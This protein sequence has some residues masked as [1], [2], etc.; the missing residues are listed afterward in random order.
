M[1]TANFNVDNPLSPKLWKNVY[2]IIVTDRPSLE[3]L[4]FLYQKLTE[5]NAYAP[6]S[7]K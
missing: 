3:N 6:D 4:H 5:F 1:C 2:D 7:A